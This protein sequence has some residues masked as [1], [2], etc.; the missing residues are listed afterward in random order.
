MDCFNLE[1]CAPKAT[2]TVTQPRTDASPHVLRFASTQDSIRDTAGHSEPLA[3]PAELQSPEQKSTGMGSHSRSEDRESSSRSK[4]SRSSRDDDAASSSKRHR[5]SHADEDRHRDKDSER[6]SSSHHHHRSHKHSSSRKR[7]DVSSS[8]RKKDAA[9]DANDDDDDEWVEKATEAAS[10]AAPQAPVDTVGTFSIGSMPTSTAGLR[11]L[12]PQ[13]MTD[14]YGQG[15][16]GGSNERGGGLFGLPGGG[17]ATT[18]EADFFGSF[19]TERRRK[20]P[21]EKVDPAVSPR[22]RERA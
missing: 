5:R 22:H 7:D 6:K 3:F 4:H 10:A 18:D 13:D 21:K 8:G 2:R 20:E 19:G 14:G 12:E 9:H 17:G 11:R 1:P 15:D 16:V